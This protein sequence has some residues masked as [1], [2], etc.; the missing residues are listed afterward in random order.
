MKKKL[1]NKYQYDDL[2]IRSRDPYANAKYGII[3]RWLKNENIKTVLNAGCGSGELS[4]ILAQNGFKVTS[5]DLDKDYIDLANKNVKKMKIKN[6]NF[7]V[8]GIENFKSKVKYDAV[9]ATDVLEHIKDDKFAF[10]M[11]PVFI[12]KNGSVVITVPAG[13]YLFG[14]HDEQ[15][16]HFRRYSI[17]SFKKIIPKNLKTQTIRYFGFFLIPIAYLVSKLLR[18]SYPVAESGDSKNNFIV[19]NLLNI[20]LAIEK[21]IPIPIGTSIL[22]KGRKLIK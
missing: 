14:F 20:F 21:K 7:I 3:L 9:I 15:L 17:S 6:C 12:K 11:L 13:Q 22:F 8:S 16:G 4:F 19:K 10:K 2:L 5:F 18:K 1:S